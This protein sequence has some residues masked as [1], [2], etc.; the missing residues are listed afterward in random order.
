[1]FIFNFDFMEK[2]D[3][4]HTY[5]YL[6]EAK[7]MDIKMKNEKIKSLEIVRMIAFA[8]VFIAHSGCGG[9]GDR[10]GALGVSLFLILAGFLMA[11]NYYGQSRINEI[12]LPS[13][14]YFATYKL[15]NLF[16]LHCL[17]L[18]ISNYSEPPLFKDEIRMT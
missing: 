6:S 4:N 16:P 15:K 18:L 3:W 8:C 10:L 7:G 17:T 5:L 2:K 13:N 14:V 9:E 12:S 11:Y 1:M